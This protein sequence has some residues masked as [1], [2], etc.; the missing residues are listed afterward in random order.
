MGSS[1]ALPDDLAVRLV[2]IAYG[3]QGINLYRFAS[4]DGAVLPG[5]EPGAHVDVQISTEYRRQYS[6]LWP[7]AT[8]DSYTVAVQV[9]ENGRGGSKTLHYQSQVGQTYRLSAPRNHFELQSANSNDYPRYVLFAGGI[10]ITP[11]V[12]MYRKLLHEHARV[13]LYYW[14]AHPER[15][16][17]LDELL[18]GDNVHIMH[19]T[20]TDTSWRSIGDIVRSLPSDVQ[21]Y[22]CGPAGM[23]DEFDMVCA[24]RPAGSAHRERFSAAVSVPADAFQVHLKRSNLTLT[25]AADETLLQKCLDAG[26]DVPYSC[27]EGV[28]GA[29]E[30]RILSGKVD[31][32]DSVLTA[33]QRDAQDRMMV[34]CSRGVGASLVLDL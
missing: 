4:L 14:T 19:Q 22:C 33:S 28:C 2:D 13:E 3:A 31:H 5:F 6:L 17:F 23:L 27:E 24:D 10:G 11:I 26:V 8:P 16:L 12:S 1:S 15:T 7:P 32:R 29:C 34:C 18:G 9:A 30:S 20:Q 21:L 25:V